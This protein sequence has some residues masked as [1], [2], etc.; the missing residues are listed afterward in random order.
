MFRPPSLLRLGTPINW[1][2]TIHFGNIR[3]KMYGTK[4]LF[5]MKQQVKVN[6]E[7]NHYELNMKGESV[8]HSQMQ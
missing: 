1:P 8:L 4:A 5:H 7:K 3:I 2:Y 6:K